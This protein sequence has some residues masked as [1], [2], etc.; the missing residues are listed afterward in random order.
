[1]ESGK[2]AS[3]ETLLGFGAEVHVKG[4][5]YFTV[6]NKFVLNGSPNVQMKSPNC[7]ARNKSF[8]TKNSDYEKKT[9]I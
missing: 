7:L 2:P 4:E 6:E 3:V 9:D 5:S 1:V 8:S